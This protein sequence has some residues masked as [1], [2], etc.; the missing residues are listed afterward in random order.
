M[1]HVQCI[2]ILSCVS[3]KFQKS[4]NGSLLLISY[5][6]WIK[7][8]VMTS[9]SRSDVAKTP[10][11]SC[12]SL[13][14][15]GGWA[16]QESQK[17]RVTGGCDPAPCHLSNHLWREI[18]QWA[19]DGLWQTA[20]FLSS[21]LLFYSNTAADILSSTIRQT[22]HRKYFN[23]VSINSSLGSSPSLTLTY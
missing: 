13:H 2:T 20:S 19:R 22:Q 10:V 21:A 7:L 11:N 23:R 15:D 17:E 12:P 1:Y 4:T 18:H 3:N 8:M 14:N 5:Q 16:C 9:W 6:T